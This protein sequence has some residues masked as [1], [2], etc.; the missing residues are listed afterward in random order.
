MTLR[1]W[2]QAFIANPISA[3][4]TADPQRKP[5]TYDGFGTEAL[6]A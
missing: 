3:T 2:G 5:K 4:I 6:I 1:F